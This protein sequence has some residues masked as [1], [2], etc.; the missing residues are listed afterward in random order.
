M[1]NLCTKLYRSVPGST[2]ISSNDSI[3][4]YPASIYKVSKRGVLAKVETGTPQEMCS[5]NTLESQYKHID[6][7]TS[8]CAYDLF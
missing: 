2:N 1:Y 8:S 7:K 6:K 3:R 5:G 4:I